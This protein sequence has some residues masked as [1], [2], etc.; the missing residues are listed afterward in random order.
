[1]SAELA[2]EAIDGKREIPDDQSRISYALYCIARALADMARA[3]DQQAARSID[4]LLPH[5]PETGNRKCVDA[6]GRRG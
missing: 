3:M 1:M 5:M 2:A 6:Q 4:S